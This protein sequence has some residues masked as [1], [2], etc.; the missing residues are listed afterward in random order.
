[1]SEQQT[2]VFVHVGSPKTGTTFLQDV[3]WSQRDKAREQGLL[4]PMDRFFDHFLATLDVRGLAERPEHP[5]RAEGIWQRMVAEAEAWPGTVLIS[6]ELFAGANAKQAAKAI[7]AFSPD[8]E[9]HVVLTARDLVRQI[10]AEWQEHLKHRAGMTLPDFSASIS[11]D[12]RSKSW[13]WRVQDYAGVL[14]RWGSTLPAS[15]VH[16]VTVPPAGAPPGLLWTRF[17]SILGL[18]P[19]SFETDRPAANTSLG[20]EQAELLRRVNLELGDRLPLPGPYAG[21]VKQVLAHRVLAGRPGTRLSLDLATTELAL[22]RSAAIVQRLHDLGVDVVGDLDELLPDREQALAAAA[23]SY[24]EPPTEAVLDEGVAALAGVLEVL[25]DRRAQRRY[26]RLAEEIQQHP[27]RFVLRRSAERHPAVAR[28]RDV[29][30]KGVD[31][32][33]RVRRTG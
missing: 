10:T 21:V 7:E 13:F 28:T 1:M 3:L 20:L 19:D 9:V 8:T 22:E 23:P 29:Y 31:L 4:L 6:H 33:R 27:I 18:D 5:E 25:A 32:A 12:P 2:R 14:E 17:A 15:R 26:E 11:N 24:E 30:R 16:V